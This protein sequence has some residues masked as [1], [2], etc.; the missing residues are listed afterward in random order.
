M[1][2]TEILPLAG[3]IDACAASIA[4]A[5]DVAA[6]AA[7][8][9]RVRDVSVALHR[10]ESGAALVTRMLSLLNDRI[11]SRLLKLLVSRFR[12]P[13]ARWCWLGLGSEGRLEQTLDTDQDNG[14][15]F[16]ASDDG[17]A[18]Q[19]RELFLPFARAVNEGLAECGFPLCDGGVMAGNPRWCLSRSE[20]LESFSGWVRTPEPEA[21]LNAAIFFDF[22]PLHGDV[23]LAA[24]LRRAVSDLTRGNEIFLRMMTVNALAA[25][26]PLGRLRDFAIGPEA[27]GSI[28]LKKFGSRIFVDAAR[29][30]ALGAGIAGTGTADRLRLVAGA[31][32]VSGTD[33]E[34][35]VHAFHAVQGIRLAA[36]AAAARPGNLVD[37]LRLNDF[38][39]RVL[40]EGL[41][42]ARTMQ[43][44]LRA[45]YHIET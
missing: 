9:A 42:Q 3:A 22:R 30:L 14:L 43:Q 40:L 16:S 29:I 20:W 44:L 45:R 4:G 11:V 18:H 38:D 1:N 37:P 12:L 15:V 21:L 17:E 41:R 39:R 34:A 28:D 27:G 24:E 8:A 35:W 26:P 2:D 6:L 32:V 33:A 10:E 25:S 5:G 23:G 13:P 19:L 36:Q 31:G 7:G